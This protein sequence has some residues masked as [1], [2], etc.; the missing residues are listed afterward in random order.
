MY[1][2]A[3]SYENYERVGEPYEKEG[4]LYTKARC[5]CDRCGGQGLIAA[6]VE[7]NQIVPIP[8]DG[9][10]CYKCGG[11]KTITKEVR[12]YTEKERQALDRAAEKKAEAREKAVEAKLAER[13]SNSEKNKKKWLLTNGFNEDGVTYCV[14]G[15][16]TFSIKEQLKE[17]GCKFSPVLLWHSPVPLDLPDGYGLISFNFEDLME[18]N[19]QD[20]NAYFYEDSKEKVERKIRELE[21]PSLSEYVGEVGERLYNITAVYKSSRGFNGK[22]GWTNIHTFQ[23][24][25]DVL[26]W[27]TQKELDIEKGSPVDLTGTIKKH[28]E[29]RGVKTTQL[30]RCIIKVII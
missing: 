1:F 26:V 24:D 6:R 3:K 8:V 19:A 18:W 30:S 2:T 9:G 21:G 13:L 16:D 4:K 7:N 12:L 23:V 29:F 25:E 5:T 10:I 28:E 22:F 14:Y 15:D 11:A 17:Q 27:F 20:N